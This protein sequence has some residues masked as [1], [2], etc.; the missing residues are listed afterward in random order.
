MQ[1]LSGNSTIPPELAGRYTDVR[2]LGSGASGEVFRA[3]DTILD[4]TVAIKLLKQST[5]NPDATMRFQQEAKVASKLNH[6]NIVTL[7]DFGITSKSI[8]FLVMECAEGMSLAQILDECTSLPLEAAVNIILQVCEG[9]E[10]AHKNGIVHR[11]LK[12]S[13]IIVNGDNPG[14]A[15]VKVL[16]FG[17]AKLE[18]DSN[19]AG[20]IT[21]KGFVVGTPHYMSPEQFSGVSVDRRTDIYSVGCIFFRIVTGHVPFEGESVLEIMQ[22][23]QFTAPRISDFV[24][25]IP[26]EFDTIVAKCL[27]QDPEHRYRSMSG[28]IEALKLGIEQLKEESASQGTVATP[29]K[30]KQ[31]EVGKLRVSLVACYAILSACLVPILFTRL[32]TSHDVK[33]AVVNDDANNK[34]PMVEHISSQF[35]IDKPEKRWTA[36]GMIRDAELEY[37]AMHHAEDINELILGDDN[38]LSNQ[39]HI[40]ERGYRALSKIPLSALK[41]SR[42]NLDDNALNHISKI[43][44]LLHL[45]ISA[46]R[47]TDKG[48]RFLEN[49]ANLLE[50][51]VI[52]DKITI[53]GIKSIATIKNLKTLF[54]DD[55]N[56]GDKD[57]QP[58]TKLAHLTKLRLNSCKISDSGLDTVA[59]MSGLNELDFG[60][61]GVTA[62]GFEKLKHLKLAAILVESCKTFD[63]KCLAII[64]AQWPTLTSLTVSDTRITSKGIQSIGKL[65]QLTSLAMSMLPITDADMEPIFHLS[66]LEKL[67]VSLNRNLTD[68]TMARLAE[69]PAL[70]AVELNCCPRV[71]EAGYRMLA[72]GRGIEIEQYERH[73][74]TVLDFG[75]LLDLDS[76]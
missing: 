58:L 9:M 7:M 69:M 48:L 37:L 19:T 16:D 34:T 74:K 76:K 20:S 36:R 44:T 59:Q 21:K 55:T 62:K 39:V 54:L 30:Q 63:D 29:E 22:D 14:T 23:K 73:R 56:I 13:N 38:T 42:T 6:Q 52:G 33:P 53:D 67:N 35:E 51:L 31:R 11:D 46:T 25:N 64:A 12:P 61:T 41:V 1:N 57:L 3:H 26:S 10:H 8:P 17:I 49:N 66:K 43:P 72:K 60:K 70:T 15:S 27:E 40:T 45:N 2:L 5:L 71:T 18:T 28:M 75:S 65:N 24:N 50:L 47:V 32:V 68:K 4:K